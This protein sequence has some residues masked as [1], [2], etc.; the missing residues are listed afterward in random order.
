MND[1]NYP[2]VPRATTGIDGLD[3]VLGGGLPIGHMYL[4]DGAPGSGKTTLGLQFLLAGVK[5][6]RRGV[7]VTL[8]ETEDELREISRG[9]GWD[10][11]G[12]TICDLQTAEQSLEAEAQYT[13]FHPS[14]V[15]LT[16]TTEQ[17][18][19]A[20][21]RVQPQNVVF[22]SLSEMRLLAR[23]SLR[24]RRQ[25]LALKHY[26]SRR[27][28]TVLLIDT[29]ATA[30]E[31]QISSI[32]H[33]VLDLEQLAPVYGG[34][35]RRL[36][37]S[38][39][40]GVKYREGW[41][42]YRIVRGGVEV[43][44]RL[45]AGEHEG[46]FET[47]QL[48]SGV[49]QLDQLVGGGLERG[50]STL[51]LGSAGTGKSTVAMQYMRAAAERGQRSIA[52]L[53]DETV[54]AWC[55]R[56][57]GLNMGVGT[58]LEQGLIQ[59]RQV[60][61]AEL[62]PGEFAHLMRTAVEQEKVE[63]VVIDTV[64]GYESAMPEERFLSLHLHELLSYLS[65]KGVVTIMTAVQHGL[66]GV[67]V[68]TPVELSYIAD[69]VLLLRY[70]EAFGEVRQMISVVK[71]RIGAHEKKIREMRI[72]APEGIVVGEQLRDFNGVLTGNPI[73]AGAK[74]DLLEGKG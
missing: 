68:D 1:E 62:S 65:Q 46:E 72:R 44:P 66:V 27:G 17:V 18:L 32:A 12:V 31:F 36:R 67:H 4:V 54:N 47:A 19:R 11:E 22:D 9:H 29:Q 58:Y 38:K 3:D 51:L 49:P 8:S 24:Y 2:P 28:A 40:R 41:H 15:E 39:V 30:S 63:I 21:E 57:R 43:Y 56:A 35:R 42:D 48:S 69:T 64:N 13:L 60:N 37:F 59:L 23:D 26:F 53:F 14:E 70:F 25:I 20:V 45:E 5:H 6:G 33:G 50:T 71:K 34:Q 52:F 16:E 7:Y 74:P 10:L 61:A 55:A 73:F